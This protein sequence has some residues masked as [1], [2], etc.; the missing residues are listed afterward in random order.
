MAI[1]LPYFMGQVNRAARYAQAGMGLHTAGWNLLLIACVV[2]PF[3]LLDR[4]L[5]TL[6]MA[7]IAGGMVFNAAAFDLWC[8]RVARVRASVAVAALLTV[9]YCI[10][11]NNYPFRVGWANGLLAL[12]I[13]MVVVSLCRRPQVRVGRW[14][15]LLVI[16]LLAQMIV[17]GWRGV[18]GAFYTEQFPHF[19]A[20]HMVNMVFSLVSNIT[21]M[22]SLAAVLL[23]HRDETARE[24]ERL[25]TVDGLTG[26]LNRRA[27][28]E[29]AGIDRAMSVR[30]RQPMGVLMLDLDYFK[31]INDTRGHAVGDLAL[32]KFSK[33]MLAVSRAGDLCCRY[34]GEEFCV[35]LNRADIAAVQAYDQRLRDWL[36]LHAPS[37]L[38]FELSYSAGIA[39]RLSDADTIEAMLQRADGAM[40]QAKQQG[41]GMT[42]APD[43]QQ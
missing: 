27:W 13:A 37:K 18:L 11:Y 30:Y 3:S 28:L 9:G 7:A 39:M 29:Q 25:A 23:A 32:Q 16:S 10:G 40:Y 19:F 5:S 15:W 43:R 20:P 36:R 12:Q 2:T 6:S 21:V 14:R 33:A 31:Q 26:A 24:L 34:G 41:R 22:L 8:G 38:G 1:A 35:L 17:T 4:T 42:L